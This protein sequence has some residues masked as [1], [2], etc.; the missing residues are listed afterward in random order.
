MARKQ[1]KSSTSEP[2]TK[3]AN[4][5]IS[6]LFKRKFATLTLDS[7][8]SDDRL[9]CRGPLSTQ[10]MPM[11]S[12]LW[13]AG[14]LMSEDVSLRYCKNQ[15]LLLWKYYRFIRRR[16]QH[17]IQCLISVL[18][19]LTFC[20][21][22]RNHFCWFYVLLSPPQFPSYISLPTLLT[23]PTTPSPPQLPS[24]S[25]TYRPRQLFPLPANDY[26]YSFSKELAAYINSVLSPAICPH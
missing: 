1:A 16:K 3:R 12:S 21:F 10:F 23:S 15:L 13:M 7:S 14:D 18:S 9:L 24:S 22:A 26:G 19:A 8:D 11:P 2:A 4:W 17:L 25:R 6:D 5:Y 20:L